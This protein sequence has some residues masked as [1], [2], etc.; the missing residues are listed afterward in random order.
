[1]KELPRLVVLISGSGS[2]LQAV[3]N[4]CAAGDLFATVAG[5]LSNK[6]DAY[7]LERARLAQV[8]ALVFPKPKELDRRVY[9]AQLAQKVAELRPDWVL[10][11]GWMRLLSGEFLNHFPGHV[12]NIHPALPGTFPGTHAIERAFEA[13]QL[14]QLSQTGI[15]VHLVPDEGVDC[16]PVLGQA[17]V[18]ISAEDTLESL[19]TRMHQTEH[20]LL[21]EVLKTILNKTSK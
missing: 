20:Q 13:Y 19:T 16:G 15:M 18:P 8:P 12:I 6:P 21:I 2:N 7:G 14:G 9:D 1:M 10:L 17:V 5:V 4:A 11:L 3:L